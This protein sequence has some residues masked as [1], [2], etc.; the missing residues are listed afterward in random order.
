MDADGVP[1]DERDFAFHKGGLGG[2]AFY[3]K[4]SYKNRYRRAP[5]YQYRE[6][7]N[8]PSGEGGGELRP[9][10]YHSES[11]QGI[12]DQVDINKK[13]GLWPRACQATKEGRLGCAPELRPMT[14]QSYQNARSHS[15]ACQLDPLAEYQLYKSLLPK[16]AHHSSSSHH[17]SVFKTPACLLGCTRWVMDIYECKIVDGNG[18]QGSNPLSGSNPASSNT[19]FASAADQMKGPAESGARV[20][21]SCILGGGM[22]NNLMD[23]ES[24]KKIM[25]VVS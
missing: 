24:T 9:P 12:L 7:E 22:A 15:S 6:K 19:S 20:D 11:L 23:F 16:N 3:Q 2:K 18:N 8:I 13:Q 25:T 17:S 4:R 5:K 14:E 21:Q 1:K 10:A